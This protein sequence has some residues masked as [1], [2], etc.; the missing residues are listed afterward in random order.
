LSCRCREPAACAQRLLGASLVKEHQIPV[1]DPASI[2]LSGEAAPSPHFVELRN[3]RISALDG[4]RARSMGDA[5]LFGPCAYPDGCTA[6]AALR[7]LV[8]RCTQ[9]GEWPMPLMANSGAAGNRSS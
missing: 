7:K 2:P 5:C 1:A 9:P 3:A 6:W 8:A 4:S